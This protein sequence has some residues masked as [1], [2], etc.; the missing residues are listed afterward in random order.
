MV[1][2][3]SWTHHGVWVVPLTGFLV[4]RALRGSGW[5]RVVLAAILVVGSGWE[6]F[7]VPS[8]AH[9]ELRWSLLQAVPGNAYV[10]AAMLLAVFA[11]VR[12]LRRSARVELAGGN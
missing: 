7:V 3:L 1:C 5:A 4:P 8:G 2:P 10:L 6:F 9:V 11:V 12:V